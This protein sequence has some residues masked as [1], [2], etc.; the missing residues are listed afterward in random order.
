MMITN[1]TFTNN[2]AQV[3]SNGI[4][5][6]SSILTMTNVTV[7]NSQIYSNLTVVS[8]FLLL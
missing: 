5:L 7:T 1:T 2:Q 4:I 8:G 6:E 3:L